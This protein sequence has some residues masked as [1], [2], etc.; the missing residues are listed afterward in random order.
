[1]YVEAGLTEAVMVPIPWRTAPPQLYAV[2]Y[3]DNGRAT[4][5]DY[6][7]EDLPVLVNGEP[8]VVA[9]EVTYP[10]DVFIFDQPV[11]NEEIV[12]ERV[13]SEGPGWLAVH[14]DD[15]GQ[16]GL[17]I[18]IAPLEDGL[19]EQV[20]V[21]L[22]ETPVTN[23]LFIML[24]QDEDPVGQFDFPGPD[25]HRLYQGNV[26][27]P[28][29][30]NI[31][32]GNSLYTHDQPLTVSEDNVTVTVVIPLIIADIDTWI[33]IRNEFN[34]DLGDIIGLTWVPAGVN[35]DVIVVIDPEQVTDTLYA[36]LH[37]DAEISQ[38]F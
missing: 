24:H 25:G 27:E 31:N 36:I 19:N 30:F 37:L 38:E 13:I 21:L 9:I 26:V 11:V 20:I 16:L 2:L 34:D 6:P 15:E 22:A 35:R 1:M 28:F 23:Q 17:I 14:A 29:S 33:V 12:V 5:F 32:P 4:R 3:E 18:G 8:L 10:P 7:D